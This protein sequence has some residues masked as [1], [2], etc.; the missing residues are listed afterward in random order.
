MKR[1]PAVTRV[2]DSRAPKGEA[3]YVVR[4]LWYLT[5]GLFTSLGELGFRHTELRTKQFNYLV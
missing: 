1:E 5:F 3:A 4:T 2:T